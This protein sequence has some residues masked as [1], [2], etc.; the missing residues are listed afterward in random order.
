LNGKFW[1]NLAKKCSG[2]SKD[3]IEL[4]STI[5]TILKN[6]CNMVKDILPEKEK[7]RNEMISTYRKGIFISKI[8]RIIRGYIDN[9][10]DI[11]NEE[12]IEL[13][14]DYDEYYKNDYYIKIRDSKFKSIKLI[15]LF[16]VEKKKFF[17]DNPSFE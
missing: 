15:M 16:L 3:N 13:I 9:N 11:N 12:I 6:Y 14:R 1:E 8:H 17:R 5:R 10:Q 2:I 7:L 4:C